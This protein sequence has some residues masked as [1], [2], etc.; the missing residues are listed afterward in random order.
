MHYIR[1]HETQNN[2]YNRGTRVIF[3]FLI[4]LVFHGVHRRTLTVATRLLPCFLRHVAFGSLWLAVFDRL[5][6]V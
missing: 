2:K 4:R 6:C 3:H 1:K 5:L